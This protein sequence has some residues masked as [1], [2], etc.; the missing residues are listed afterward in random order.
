MLDQLEGTRY[1][2]MMAWI[3]SDRSEPFSGVMGQQTEPLLAQMQL[4]PEPTPAMSNDDPK[5]AETRMMARRM[6]RRR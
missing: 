4:D 2:H 5:E 3:S 6:R 1:T